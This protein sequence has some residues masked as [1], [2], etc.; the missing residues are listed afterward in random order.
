MLTSLLIW[1]C[2]E[3]RLLTPSHS[4][5]G[6]LWQHNFSSSGNGIFTGERNRQLSCL[7][8][9]TEWFLLS[10]YTFKSKRVNISHFKRVLLLEVHSKRV[11]FFAPLEWIFGKVKYSYFPHFP[12]SIILSHFC[13]LSCVDIF[14]PSQSFESFPPLSL[15]T[16]VTASGRFVTN[17][18]N[19]NN[20]YLL[21]GFLL[22]PMVW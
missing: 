16:W 8:I 7:Q 11:I 20:I 2:T 5:R 4:D 15:E 6:K 17:A 14:P 13:F 22:S 10:H 1:D 18:N 21:L 9:L 3:Y 19:S 12:C